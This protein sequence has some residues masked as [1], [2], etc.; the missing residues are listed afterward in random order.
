MRSSGSSGAPPPRRRKPSDGTRRRGRSTRRGSRGRRP[1]AL[2]VGVV[3]SPRGGALSRMLPPF[4]AGLGGVIG[5]GRQY[6]SWI[7]LDDLVGGV[8]HA[9]RSGGLRGPG[10]AVAPVPVTNRELTGGL[11]QG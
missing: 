5:N 1:V 4:R 7:A 9:L 8:L 11:G 6:V 2:R 3:L 10:N